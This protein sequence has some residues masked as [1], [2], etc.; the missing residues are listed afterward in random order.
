MNARSWFALAMFLCTA[1][2]SA[3]ETTHGRRITPNDVDL[4]QSGGY[5]YDG[6][7][8]IYAI[9]GDSYHYDLTGRLID[10]SVGAHPQT[11]RY[12]VFGNVTRVTT[13][14]DVL[15][16]AVDPLT[17]QLAPAGSGPGSV[18]TATYDLAGNMIVR[19]GIFHYAYD[20][21]NMVTTLT[22]PGQEELY[23]YGPGE[24]RIATVTS[25]HAQTPHWSWTLRDGARVLRRLESSGASAAWSEDY[26]Y[27]DGGVL[28]TIQSDGS[29]RHFHLDHLGS[30]RVVT[31]DEGR[32]ISR[33]TYYPFGRE[34]DP[35]PSNEERVRFTGHE[36]DASLDYM[37]ARYYTDVPG[38]FLTI[39][40]VLDRQLAAKEPQRW[41]QYAYVVDSPLRFRDPDG[42]Q[43]K[44]TCD[45][46]K[47]PPPPMHDMLRLT[48]GNIE[49]QAK[50]PPKP[51]TVSGSD[52]KPPDPG[53]LTVTAGVSVN[54]VT[55]TGGASFGAAVMHS[56][57]IGPEHAG[58]ELNGGVQTISLKAS[59][60]IQ[61][62]LG[63]FR[64]DVADQ[65]GLF[66][67]YNASLPDIGISVSYTKA[68]GLA[69]ATLYWGPSVGAG[70]STSETN[71]TLITGQEFL[72]KIG[73]SQ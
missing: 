53:L 35:V 33:H 7:G 30:A 5:L 49:Q 54:F 70:F 65:R 13:G 56:T 27:R 16:P 36:R 43:M 15:T 29:T 68:G 40:P 66:Q 25:I 52:G 18:A 2:L 57:A 48:P 34:I 63:L 62:S 20:A 45:I 67:D 31:T 46:E 19:D 60:G 73:Y 50:N 3:A 28:A 51:A 44:P 41:N 61:G 71:T 10:A 24:Q 37:H 59:A 23:I 42:R 39:D 9:G 64:G 38:R 1:A 58:V 55:P 22:G 47:C 72:N 26:V 69:G 12:D 6:S 17:N 32:A 21:T 4:W 14:S 11:F 8:N